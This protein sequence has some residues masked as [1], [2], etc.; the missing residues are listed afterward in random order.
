MKMCKISNIPI[1]TGPKFIA[2]QAAVAVV[3]IVI[4][5]FGTL[6]N[7]LVIMA[8]YRNS[9]LR[10][11]QN[12][13]FFLLAIT[14]F[15]VNAFVEPMF[16]AAIINDLLEKRNC[17]LWDVNAMLFKLFVGLSLVTIG[18]LS[19]QSYITL[20]YPYRFHSIITKFRLTVTIVFS[21]LLVSTLTIAFFLREDVF[22]Y[23]HPCILLTT[24]IT[25][26]FSWI[27]IYKLV[28]RHR[29]AIQTTQT[30]ST[31]QNIS[32]RKT[33]RSTITAFVII[34]SL[35]G[36]YF[37]GLFMFFSEKFLN[38]GKPTPSTFRNIWS[39]AM[40]LVY[41]NSLLNPCLV[42]WRTTS[43]RQTVENIFIH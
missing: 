17:L 26:I 9:R 6:A 19:L 15:S 16:V 36:C 31:G 39:I 1:P 20:A 22:I 14:D 24:I 42:F 5:L 18:I 41:L 21:W 32:R 23:A 37:L 27:W 8:Y 29:R 30:P 13:I 33:V 28:A 40:T 11:I 34:A 2:L 3:N 35:V 4:A 7:G 43:F 12:T 10:T 25:V 38:R